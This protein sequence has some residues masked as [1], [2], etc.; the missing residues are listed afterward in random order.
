MK[1]TSRELNLL[2]ATLA[3]ALFGAT[4]LMAR[5]RVTQWKALKA[6]Q[7]Q[8]RTE[9]EQD[10]RLLDDRARWEQEFDSLRQ[11]LPQFPADK[12]MD[13]HWLSIMDSLA[14]KHGVRISRRDVGEEKRLGD[15]YELPIDVRDW[16]GTLES[17]VHFL[18]EL[19]TQGAMLDI[20]QLSM[21]P[22]EQRVL[23]G[24][25]I[26]YCAFTREGPA[27]AADATARATEN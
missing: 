17:L 10:Q 16:E 20:R 6:D 27:P 7:A 1:V 11:Y 4:A 3:V 26:L 23:R 13:I 9:I 22:N 25:F 8:Q 15:V 12:K 19:Q 21:K 5:P 2:L 18:F 24:R 14:S